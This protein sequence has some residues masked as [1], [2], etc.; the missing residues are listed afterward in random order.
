MPYSD[1]W[2][3]VTFGNGTFAAVV[4]G[5]DEAAYSTNGID[6]SAGSGLPE[7]NWASVTY[8][9][10]VFAAIACYTDAGAYSTDGINW[11]C[12][13]MPNWDEWYSSA[14][15]GG[16]FVT[17]SYGQDLAYSTD[18][19]D[20]TA[21]LGALPDS[22]YW[23]CFAAGQLPSGYITNG[24]VAYWK[25]NDGSG[26][27]AP[28]SSGNG[29]DLPL[30][31]SPSRGPDY[32]T[33]NGTDQYGDYA[34]SAFNSLDA[35]NLSICAWI[36]K[37]GSSQRGIV[38][39]YTNESG[40]A[41]WTFDILSGNQL[42]WYIANGGPFTDTGPAAITLGQW[43]FVTLTWYYPHNTNN[44]VTYYINGIWNSA[45]GAGGGTQ[46][47]SDGVDLLVGSIFTTTSP[48][49]AFDGS[50]HDVAIYNRVLSNSEVASNFLNTEFKTD[51]AY[52][53]LLYYKMTNYPAS[54]SPVH[55]TDS[56]T[57]GGST[58]LMYVDGGLLW[59]PNVGGIPDSAIHF[60]GVNSYLVAS[61]SSNF[62]FTTNSFTI[63]LWLLPENGGGYVMGNNSYPT[64]GWF[65]AVNSNH[66]VFGAETS[67]G[68]AAIGTSNS[69][70]GWP[71]NNWN[72]VTV[73][74]D[75]TNTPLIYING[76]AVQ[77][78]SSSYFPNPISTTNSLI[79]GSGIAS[80]TDAYLDGDIWQPQI[81]NIALL[82]T[83]VANLYF[84]QVSGIPWP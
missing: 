14:F 47:G 59:D 81:W 37:T 13:E 33:L 56:S 43:T 67:V 15:T 55:F 74:R 17:P 6:W 49:Y 51:V 72:M 57:S 44:V 16:T 77:L 28:D 12:A 41:G 38:T 83:D 78:S 35:T 60:N 71:S 80:N 73:T 22:D 42:D 65:M 9:N 27:T 10:G 31:S 46:S 26:S 76:G 53:D 62:N 39:K 4:G 69:I 19:I 23:Y 21:S 82:P 2:Q 11:T 54:N 24:L 5:S 68:E 48:N 7:N 25:F 36:N 1:R 18:G 50:M 58:G 20:W 66:V 79:F 40:Y 30:V 84:N 61:N 29:N 52:P 75:G 64:N 3:S 45:P 63:N 8:G 34:G 32:L 70:I